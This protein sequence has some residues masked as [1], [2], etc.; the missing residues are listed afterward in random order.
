MKADQSKDNQ[1]RILSIDDDEE[2]LYALR[3]VIESQGWEGIIARDVAEALDI[4]KQQKP[5]LILIDY[6]MPRINGV[7]GVEM[8]RKLNSC[9]PI[10]VFTIDENQEIA[11]RFLEAGASDFATKPIKAPDIISRI[12]L[13]IRLLETQKEEV[14]KTAEI[15]ATKGI[16]L[17]TMELIRDALTD[18]TEYLT[19]EEIAQKTG[20]AFQTA[21]RYMQHLTSAGAVDVKNT[22]GKKGRPK[23]SFHLI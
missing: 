7:Q 15:F 18:E 11:D 3:A 21:Y 1:I 2:I 9:I 8:L 4:Y 14:K 16:G 22:Y 10:I 6:H 5:D 19:V 12:K 20:L 23:Q 17:S 13:H